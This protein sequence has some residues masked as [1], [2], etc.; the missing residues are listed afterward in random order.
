MNCIKRFFLTFILALLPL[1]SNGQAKVYT[2]KVKLADFPV[3]TTKVVLGGCP[4]FS[5]ALR[6]AVL[7]YWRLSPYEFCTESEYE[8]L[9]KDNTLYF[10]RPVE[11]DGTMTLVLT[12]GGKEK[13]SDN[14][15]EGFTIV[16]MPAGDQYGHF[17]AFIDIIQD[18]VAAAMESDRI[19]YAGL[20][21]R[22]GPGASHIRGLLRNEPERVCRVMIG[23]CSITY[24]KETHELCY[25]RK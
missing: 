11:T 19:A 20:K 8:S 17:D 3:R 24:D 18:F 12:K 15:K 2:M 25:F 22:N 21:Y 9:K 5:D 16:E 6:D 14:L 13:D 1:V 7:H 23:H 10:L 4:E